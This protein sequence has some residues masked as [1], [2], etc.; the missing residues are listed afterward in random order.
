M[1]ISQSESSIL[2]SCPCTAPI[3]ASKSFFKF[4]LS[5]FFSYSFY[6]GHSCCLLIAAGTLP[7]L[8]SNLGRLATHSASTPSPLFSSCLSLFLPMFS[9]KSLTSASQIDSL[10]FIYILLDCWTIGVP[11]SFASSNLWRSASCYSVWSTSSAMTFFKLNLINSVLAGGF[12]LHA[13]LPLSNFG[14]F[15][16]SSVLECVFLK[17]KGIKGESSSLAPMPC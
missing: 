9:I 10:R 3:Q 15:S 14:L 2:C 8:S 6:K 11:P 12:S 17:E 13:R 4:S 5:I 1:Q 16:R 7:A